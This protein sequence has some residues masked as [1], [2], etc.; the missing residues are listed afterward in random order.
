MEIKVVVTNDAHYVEQADAEMHELTVCMSQKRTLRDPSRKPFPYKEFYLKS[1]EEMWKIFGTVPQYMMNTVEV[2]EKTDLTELRFGG[3][4]LPL[5]VSPTEFAT[6]FDH[7][8]HLAWKGLAKR[9]KSKNE[10]YVARLNLELSDIKLVLDTKN[11][12]FPTYFLIVEDIINRARTRKPPIPIDIRG[13]GCGS[14][15]LYALY[16]SKVDPIKY[17]LS[18]NRFLGF[19]SLFF[20]TDDDFGLKPVACK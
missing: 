4:T 13:S 14:L 6:P 19:D 18:W 1:T 12:D 11:Y 16:I 5:F 8:S 20:F 2:A 7:L 9:G 15:L 17:G 3:M 10:E